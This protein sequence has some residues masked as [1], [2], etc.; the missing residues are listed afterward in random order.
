MEV[1]TT[2][3]EAPTLL[4]PV[5]YDLI[6]KPEPGQTGNVCALAFAPKDV[7]GG[8]HLI[9]GVYPLLIFSFVLCHIS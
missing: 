6:K 2:V 4:K 3:S 1:C 5:I 7:E 8:D 9:S